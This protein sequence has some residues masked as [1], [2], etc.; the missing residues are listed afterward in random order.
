MAESGTDIGYDLSALLSDDL[1]I[2]SAIDFDD[3]LGTPKNQ[4]FYELTSKTMPVLESTPN[5]KTATTLSRTQLK[6]QLMRD[7]A[8]LEQ[9]RQAQERLHRASLQQQQQHYHNH[10]SQHLI[11][12]PAK[13][14]LHSITEVPPQV[15][16]VRTRLENPTKYHVMEKQKYQVKQ[17]LSESLQSSGNNL[18]FAKNQRFNQT[19]SAPTSDASNLVPSAGS[20]NISSS[21]PYHTQGD[22]SPTYDIPALSPALSSGA[23]STSEISGGDDACGLVPQGKGKKRNFGKLLELVH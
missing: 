8:M 13:V 23:T 5:L 16:Q 11:A 21:Q 15:L 17:Y 22:V 6:L 18:Q 9:Q 4:E 1:D 2:E 14:P 20:T 10:H 19:R 3:L 12:P 7:H